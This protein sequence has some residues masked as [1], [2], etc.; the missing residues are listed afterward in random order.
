MD[1]R[2]DPVIPHW[3]RVWKT[4]GTGSCIK[5]DSCFAWDQAAW[6]K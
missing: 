2:L 1:M 6:S 3:V 4:L 5:F